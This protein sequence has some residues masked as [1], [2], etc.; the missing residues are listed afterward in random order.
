MSVLLPAAFAMLLAFAVP[1]PLRRAA[2]PVRAPRLG[3]LAWQ[4]TSG[5]VVAA[6]G[7]AATAAL[8]HWDP[9]HAVVCAAWRVC[10]DALTGAHG[11]TAQAIAFA[12]LAT[13]A[14][15]V[16][17]LGTA[18]RRVITAADNSR[19]QHQAL[20]VH[21]GT[22]RADLG[23]TVVASPEPAAYL[24]PG[25]HPQVV[26]TTGALLR[27]SAPQLAAVVAHERA[28]AKG[29]H[30]RLRD[31]ARMLNR[32]FPRVPVFAHAALEVGRLVELRADDVA[33]RDHSPLAMAYAL[34]A[35]ATPEPDIHVVGAGGG[36]AAE[37][38]YRLLDPPRPLSR[39][40][41]VAVAAGCLAL[42]AVPVLL[43][44]LNRILPAVLA[45]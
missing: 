43:V 31:V 5:A 39:P 15:L 42:P 13:L 2:W 34:A 11:R 27:L 16:L 25:S 21:A 29:H 8:L 1:S 24:V 22:P 19:R 6:L 37:R 17:R 33:A 3:I 26:V 28:H 14:I 9:T 10:V 40:V 18:W 30:H 45:I 44:L 36:D 20:L 7:T 23:A 4:T 12:G 32:A 35:L 38:L 41:Q